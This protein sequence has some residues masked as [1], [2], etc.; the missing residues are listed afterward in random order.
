[1]RQTI[2]SPSA[3]LLPAWLLLAISFPASALDDVITITNIR[4]NIGSNTTRMVF[5]ADKPVPYTSAEKIETQKLEIELP[6][7]VFQSLPTAS[8]FSN[9]AIASVDIIA[10]EGDNPAKIII[11]LRRRMIVSV[12]PYAPKDHYGHRLVMDFI[13][14]NKIEPTPEPP[15]VSSSEI[16]DT[17]KL[18]VDGQQALARG[19]YA[20]ALSIYQRLMNSN[21]P[22]VRQKAL[23]YYAV[24]LEQSGKKARAKLEYSNYLKRYPAGDD[25]K[26][27]QQRLNAMLSLE[28]GTRQLSASK[29]SIDNGPA[30]ETWGVFFEDYRW[31]QITNDEGESDT[32]LNSAYTMLDANAR[33][34]TQDWELSMRVN[35]G[36]QA[37]LLSGGEDKGNLSYL[38]A[39]GEHRST[40]RSMKLG[41]QRQHSGGTIGRFDGISLSS[42]ITD[43]V[44]LNLVAGFPVERST[45]TSV[46]TDRSFYGINADIGP[47]FDDLELNV[48]YIDQEFDGF[49]DREAVGG[50]I[51]YFGSD[52]YLSSYFDYDVH[53]NELNAFLLSG[54]YQFSSGTNA[55]LSLNFRKSPYLTTR[56][57][58]IGQQL[59]DLN[60]L[61]DRIDGLEELE[62]IALD[63]TFDSTSLNLYVDH[64][65]N[66]KV[67]ISTSLTVSELSDTPSS[68]GVAGY[69]GTD[70][71]FHFNS[72]VVINDM[73]FDRDNS[74]IG[75]TYA[76]LTHSDIYS[77]YS[78]YK[79]Q[80]SDNW[81][82]YPRLAFQT[83]DNHDNTGQDR[84]SLLL[85][86]EY[87]FLKDHRI[88]GQIGADWY[89]NDNRF[90]EQDELTIYFFNVGY[91]YLF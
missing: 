12:K 91:T 3:F 63:R 1:M 76:T 87:R 15:Q 81:R 26:R 32:R 90:G 29:R 70:T 60:D 17:D 28:K 71:E 78:H 24:S 59:D 11:Y 44:R 84:Y 30:V 9:S 74:R 53:F 16:T 6:G 21:N 33:L 46:D 73:L 57:A 55:S 51:K 49:T 85:R 2:F 58:L 27:V 13:T 14:L 68:A 83:R 89:F 4:M 61:K 47:F 79:Y 38:Y 62:D 50:E 65:I 42:P 8:Q 56:N 64:S 67:N 39:Y 86:T 52:Y 10:A 18:F 31:S 66:N 34:R 54:R 37:N 72:Q 25:A 22:E 75:F 5:D 77:I 88:D 45:N 48:F 80:L 41:R 69:E 36:Y 23:E 43:S 82:L 40:E 20:N 19:E 35:A 7:V